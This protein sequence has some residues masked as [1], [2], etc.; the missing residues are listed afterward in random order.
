[1]S[2]PLGTQLDEDALKYVLSLPAG[3]KV[4][5]DILALSGLYRQPRVA[6][7]SEGTAFNCGGLNVGL[8]L[9]ADCLTVS[10]DLTAMMT[11]EQAA[12]DNRG[13]DDNKREYPTSGAAEL[14]AELRIDRG[15]GRPIGD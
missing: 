14:P 8:A 4:L 9:Y 13:P 3:R 2:T 15:T 12:Y 11:K 1:M 5:W 6:G 7:D 10:P